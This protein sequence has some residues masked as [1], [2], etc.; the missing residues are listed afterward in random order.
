MPQLLRLEF[1]ATNRRVR[2]LL[3]SDAAGAVF[4]DPDLEEASGM[5]QDSA[6]EGQRGALT[7]GDEADLTEMLI[8]Q[9]E[10]ELDA[11]LMDYAEGANGIPPS[12]SMTASQ[13]VNGDDWIEDD[14]EYDEIF[15]EFLEGNGASDSMD[16]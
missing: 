2:E 5:L 7:T 14:R 3:R 4:L 16:I 1:L 11:Y 12:S 10:A 6:E 13:S 15:M 9:E 8:E